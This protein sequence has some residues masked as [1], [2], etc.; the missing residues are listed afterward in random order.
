[1]KKSCLMQ[2][3]L[4]RFSWVRI[5]STNSLLCSPTLASY[6]FKINFESSWSN[7]QP[8]LSIN[9]FCHFLIITCIRCST[10]HGSMELA[11]SFISRYK[12]KE[13]WSEIKII[14]YFRVLAFHNLH[15]PKLR[16]KDD[17]N[18]SSRSEILIHLVS[19]KA[20]HLGV[21]VSP[22]HAL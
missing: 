14:S 12:S 19:H 8:I 6:R 13:G 5:T 20:A 16:F 3:Y 17:S 9:S 22:K 2:Q 10:S 1:M 21:L 11:S 15:F 18:S 7:S 4:N